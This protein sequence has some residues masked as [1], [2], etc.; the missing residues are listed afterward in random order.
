MRR[1]RKIGSIRRSP[2]RIPKTHIAASLLLSAVLWGCNTTK[3]V[4]ENEHLL[5]RS[6]V[7]VEG[8]EPDPSELAAIVK[9]KPNK[10]ILGLPIYLHLYN[11]RDPE[12]VA[13]KR[14]QADSLCM[15]RNQDREVRG[16]STR[17]CNHAIRGR[18][19][20]APV[21]LD[22]FQTDRSTQQMAMYLHKEGYFQ[23]QVSDS[24]H[25]R[26]K[27]L[28]GSGRSKPFRKPKAEVVYTVVPGPTYRFRN[29]R[30]VVD[31][32]AM[33]RYMQQS[34]E[35]S[36][37]RTGDRFDADVL[38]LE[39]GRIADLM[40]DLGYLF[41]NRELVQYD[42]DTTVGGHQVDIVLR[43]E[44][45]YA[46]RDRGLKGTP[47]GT[48]YTIQDVTV[49]TLRNQRNAPLPEDTLHYDGFRLLATG[50]LPYKPNALTGGIFLRPN[51]RFRQSDAD[52]TYRRLTGLRVFDRVDITYDTTNTGRPGIANARIDLLP[53]KEQSLS[54]EGFGTNR[55]GFLGTSV[56]AGYR[57]RNLFRGM[58]SV[59]MQ[60]ILGLEAQQSITGSGAATEEAT[61]GNVTTGG[62]FN[63]VEIGP[64]I[65]FRFPNFLLPVRR[66]RFA[67]SS[68][69]RTI[70]G[71]LYNYQQRPDFV[72]TLAK[73]S[74]GY[75][76]N[77]SR[78][79]TWG[80]YPIE[81]NVIRIPSKSADFE[82]YL[83]T[84]NDPVLTDSY[85]DHLIAGMRGQFTLNTQ[86]RST[87]RNVF[88]A[89]IT[90]E[91]AGNPLFVPLRALGAEA[92]DTS[93]NAFYTVGGIR[94]AQFVKVDTD[95][96]WRRRV[97]DKSSVAF[98]VAAGAGVPF[99]NLGVLPFETSFFVGGAN[100]LRAWR[101]RSIGPGAYSAPLL[102]FDRIGEIR[103]EGN[104]EYRFKLI[105]FLE[106]AFFADVGNIWNWEEDP[107]KPGAAFSSDFLGELAV[108][109]GVGA[110]LN[111]DFFIVRF[112]LGMQ[113]KDPSLPKGERWLFQPKDR[114]ESAMEA[115]VG[116]PVNY[117]AQ[118]NFNLG[119]GYPF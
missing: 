119:I 105:G 69:P 79:K 56:S 103:L 7:K 62:L 100:G 97:D 59:Q 45:A 9:Q 28:W 6:S 68:S 43:L 109:T 2:L 96:R 90:P 82:N 78:T 32:P 80:F 116:A 72:R 19:G 84:A 36:L 50:E 27:D 47:E 95:L 21:T 117:Q 71:I 40:K 111:F 8:R 74:F 17:P 98:R 52:L 23:A 30:Y 11:L 65:T 49:A 38:D 85:T 34:W 22:P 104:A 57:H 4:P 37:V 46:K 60:L 106:G 3:Y 33:Q 113:T 18:N 44:R 20:E 35:K 58:G 115:T 92:Q 41:F 70:V 91:W 14:Q 16:K 118:F 87:D 63:T 93:G 13:I 108:G 89:R 75:E 102:A 64:E 54:L 55:G 42:A 39:R 25:Y 31:D 107:R 24:T 86:V 110:R 88:F 29:I 77:E 48:L 5:R 10:R 15:A 101:A 83:T 66:D 12:R 73:T 99:G 26:R 1:V 61:T 51:M 94:Y 67:R 53:G 112:D 114:Y 76:W 81:V